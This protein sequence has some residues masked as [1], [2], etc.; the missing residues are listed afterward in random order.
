MCDV[1]EIW[2]EEH[3]RPLP[4]PLVVPIK[5]HRDMAG[6]IPDEEL[7]NHEFKYHFY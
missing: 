7:A 4:E 6:Y 5:T 1:I 3:A 2:I